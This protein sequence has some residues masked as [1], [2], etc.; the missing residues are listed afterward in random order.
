MK[1]WGM[2]LECSPR[3][4]VVSLPQGLR[5]HVAPEEVSHSSRDGLDSRVKTST[6]CLPV[7]Y[8]PSTLTPLP[9]PPSLI[10]KPNRPPTP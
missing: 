2:V 1:V 9:P 10:Q 4:L 7:P 3:G 5:G 6:C 8:Y